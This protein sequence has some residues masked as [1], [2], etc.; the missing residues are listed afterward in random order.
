MTFA[1]FS[2]VFAVLALQLRATDADEPQARAYFEALKD[3]D[4][5]LVRAAAI[6]FAD[7]PGD[8]HAW[9]P[10]VPEWKA[11]VAKITAE[12]T[13]ELRSR[14]RSL[15]VPLCR[16]CEDT[17]WAPRATGVTRCDCQELRRLEIIGRRPMPDRCLDAVPE[18]P[19]A[20]AE[21]TALLRPKPM[22]EARPADALRQV[23]EWRHDPTLDRED[24]I[25]AAE[26]ARGRRS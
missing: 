20:L 6:R 9:F 3:L 17:G 22:P 23:S 14:L 21:V 5:E 2:N 24:P 4:L 11:G 19:H 7:E 8:N 25:I 16:V 18:R 26:L 13:E 12:R 15:P 10:R 1:E